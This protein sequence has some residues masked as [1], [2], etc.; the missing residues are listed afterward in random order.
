MSFF[1]HVEGEAAVLV[2]R[3]LYR[4]TDLYT[5]D[6]YLY[7]KHGNGFAR[8]MADGATTVPNLRLDFLTWSGP[9]LARDALGRLCERSVAGARSLDKGAEAKLLGVEDTQ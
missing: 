2:S 7:A 4:Q 6:G 8:L 9:A 3:G 1:K 5:R